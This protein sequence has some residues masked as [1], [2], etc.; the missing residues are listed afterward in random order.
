[1]QSVYSLA[2]ADWARD[3]ITHL[4]EVS[5]PKLIGINTV[6]WTQQITDRNVLQDKE[7]EGSE[8]LFKY[9]KF[10]KAAVIIFIIIIIIITKSSIL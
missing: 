2:L 8:N 4:K 7:R 10:L 5:W 9:Q 6:K 3:T 1:M